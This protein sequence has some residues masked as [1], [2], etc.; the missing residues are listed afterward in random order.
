MNARHLPLKSGLRVTRPDYFPLAVIL[1][2]VLPV[3][4]YMFR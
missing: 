3:L 2:F 1:G 4:F